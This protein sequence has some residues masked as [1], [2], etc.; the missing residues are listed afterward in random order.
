VT[1]TGDRYTLTLTF[2]DG[3]NPTYTP[4]VLALLH[5]HDATAVFCVV[6]QSVHDYPQL[7]QRTV[8][9][10]HT[11]CNHTYAHDGQFSKRTKQDMVRDISRTKEEIDSAVGGR[12]T[13]PYFRQPNTYVQPSVM[14]VLESLD[15]RPLD[16]TIDPR[17]WSRPGA[18]A[19]VQSVLGQLR[20]GAVVLL[21]DGGGDRSQTVAA[22]EQILDGIDAAGY[23]YV[24]PGEK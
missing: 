12:A 16:W 14:P 10:G 2:D 4:Q 20:P 1:E 11:L 24:M 17:D 19:I 18:D 3:P 23:R 22:L 13:V 9:A 21:H 8:A 15:L 5:K 7:V 6:G